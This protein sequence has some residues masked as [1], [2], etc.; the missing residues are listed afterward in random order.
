[1]MGVVY[2]LVNN[3][4]DYGIL[5][6][7]M[8][9]YFLFKRKQKYTNDCVAIWIEFTILKF[10]HILDGNSIYSRITCIT[11]NCV[12]CEKILEQAKNKNHSNHWNITSSRY[13]Q[14]SLKKI[15]LAPNS[16]SAILTLYYSGETLVFAG[17]LLANLP[18]PR[19]ST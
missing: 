13:L 16:P 5:M 1:M 12:Q 11:S 19:G 18:P 4:P 7:A 17:P 3:S 14:N 8:L 9:Q 10:T 15:W 2:K 6:L